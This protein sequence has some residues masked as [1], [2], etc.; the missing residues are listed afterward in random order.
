MSTIQEFDR[1]NDVSH[2]SRNQIHTQSN[3]SQFDDVDFA[4]FKRFMSQTEVSTTVSSAFRRYDR[5]NEMLCNKFVHRVT[6]KVALI[7]SIKPKY[8]KDSVHSLTRNLFFLNKISRI[9]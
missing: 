5:D 7:S 6:H 1:Q 8:L 2:Q 9:L 3:L 4:R